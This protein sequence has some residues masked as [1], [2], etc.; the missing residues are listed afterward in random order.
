MAKFKVLYIQSKNHFVKVIFSLPQDG[1]FTVFLPS[2]QILFNLKIDLLVKKW[3]YDKIQATP[4]SE[5]K[6]FIL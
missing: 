6:S 4:L 5:Q 3:R 1:Y 2:E